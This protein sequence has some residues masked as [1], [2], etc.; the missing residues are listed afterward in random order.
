MHK[1]QKPPDNSIDI[2]EKSG[3]RFLHFGSDWVQGAMRI[4][5][6]WSLELAY[7]REMMAGLLFHEAFDWPRTVLQIGLGA[8]SISRFIYRHLP[9]CRSTVVEINPQ[10][11][12]IARQ[13]FKLPDDPLKLDIKIE[14][15]VD[16]VLRGGRSFD[17][18]FVD[19][20]DA[21]AQAGALETVP[22]YQACRTRLSDKGILAVNFLGKNKGFS[23]KVAHLNEAFEGRVIVLPPCESGNIIA[24]ATQGVE[25]C[26]SGDNLSQRAETLK[27]QTQL[28]LFPTV[29]RLQK[30]DMLTNGHLRL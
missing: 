22:F 29:N 2:S 12:F 17:Y 26:V 23:A 10:I 1:R 5:K 4:A 9:Y 7:T 19:A 15:G 21:D 16:Y 27:E 6:P 11:E 25:I 24:F 28:D 20:F 8:A 18:L 3:V 13:Y 30:S 14:D